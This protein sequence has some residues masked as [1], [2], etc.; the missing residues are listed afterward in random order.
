MQ[1]TCWDSTRYCSQ[2]V[3]TW[4]IGE[5]TA[6]EFETKTPQMC[7]EPARY[8]SQNDARFKWK[9]RQEREPILG[10]GARDLRACTYPFSTLM[11]NPTRS[12][13]TDG[14][15]FW[16]LTEPSGSRGGAVNTSKHLLS[17]WKKATISVHIFL[18]IKSQPSIFANLRRFGPICNPP[19]SRR[20]TL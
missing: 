4:L 16:V 5:Q 6:F 14:W 1:G 7:T 17:V 11:I 12:T 18:K 20:S 8:F 9:C 10:A 2:L 19:T 3:A 13:W 15:C